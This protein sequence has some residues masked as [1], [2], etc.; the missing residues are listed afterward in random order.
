MVSFSFPLSFAELDA[1][2]QVWE[3]GMQVATMVTEA[4]FVVAFRVLGSLGLWS[5]GPGEN[6]RM[7]SEKHDAFAESASA[8]LQAA[9]SG[10][11][12]DQVLAAA[13]TPL[14]IKTRSNMQ[15]LAKRGPGFV[16]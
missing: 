9:Q 1:P 3:T 13:V 5:M 6:E 8:A 10:L 12:P 2:V 11:R 16:G 14:G 15:R 4:Q 7:V